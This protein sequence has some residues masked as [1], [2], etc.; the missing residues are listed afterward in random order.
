MWGQLK[1]SF[2][3]CFLK[4]NGFARIL[5]PQR[6][7]RRSWAASVLE[8]VAA[9]KRV[10]RQYGQTWRLRHML[11]PKRRILGWPYQGLFLVAEF[12]EVSTHLMNSS[13]SDDL[14]QGPPRTQ[15][16][17]MILVKNLIF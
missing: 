9:W 1:I 7:L 10:L 13:N 11:N 16:K 17:R 5:P 12:A 3:K 6:R 4:T 14:C 2:L 15:T 8:V